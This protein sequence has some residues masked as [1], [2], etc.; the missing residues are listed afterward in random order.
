MHVG[1]THIG[2][3]NKT[4]ACAAIMTKFLTADPMEICAA[5]QNENTAKENAVSSKDGASLIPQ[6]EKNR[7]KTLQITA[8]Y[9]HKKL[10][11]IH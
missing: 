1:H 5:E 8:V 3:F 4:C 11:G 9:R 6:E 10:G 7:K 2:I